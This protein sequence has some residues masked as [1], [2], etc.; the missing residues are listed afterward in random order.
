M[1]KDKAH[2]IYVSQS[3][4]MPQKQTESAYQ[5]DVLGEGYEQ[6]R[7]SFA[8]DDEGEVCATLVRKKAE[9]STSKAVLYVHGFID[10]FFQTEMAV[11]FNQ[12]G[13]DFYALDLRKYGRSHLPHQKLFYVQDLHE[14]DAEITEALNII[15]NEGHD[16]VLLSGH[17]TGGLITTLYAAHHPHHALIKGLWANSPF[18]DFNMNPIK[19]KI[20]LPHVSRIAKRFPK[21]K[22]SS[23]LNGSYVTS[24][25]NSMQGEWDFSLVWKPTEYSKVYISFV[26]AIFEAQKEIHQGVKL[27]IP[28]L[29]MHSA[30]STH[31]QKFNADA[32]SSDVI[33]NVKH[34]IKY[35]NKIQGD[36]TLVSIQDGLHDLVLSA[37][38]VRAV[39]YDKLFEWL[40]HK[41]F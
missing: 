27:N 36:V 17:S 11:K 16:S 12:Q 40:Q 31:P 20:L 18:Y 37:P 29:V 24:I 32:Q 41:Q 8:H 7:L 5:A 22:F 38:K 2:S 4:S 39:V 33:L 26:R 3:I 35:A 6:L 28:V 1:I 19:K 34:M 9:K 13:Y 23:E 14:Y 15:E 10:Y 30:R 21:F 25:H